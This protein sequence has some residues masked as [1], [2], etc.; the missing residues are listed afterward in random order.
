MFICRVRNASLRLVFT[1]SE[2]SAAQYAT[3]DQYKTRYPSI[4]L[5][6]FITPIDVPAIE[7][8]LTV[9]QVSD[10]HD[11]PCID[12]ESYWISKICYEQQIPFSCVKYV[13]DRN[14]SEDMHHIGTQCAQLRKSADLLLAGVMTPPTH[15]I[16]VIIPVGSNF[17]FFNNS[18]Q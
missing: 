16:S 15:E 1:S 7:E 3:H 8:S 5:F 2:W 17:D 6:P 13:T 10:K 11:H 4:G 18:K 14:R 12:M 9:D